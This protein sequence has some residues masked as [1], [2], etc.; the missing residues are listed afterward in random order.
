MVGPGTPLLALLRCIP[1]GIR[2]YCGSARVPPGQVLVV[3]LGIALG[4]A[5]V[6]EGV[7][8]PVDSAAVGVER[9]E[10]CGTGGRVVKV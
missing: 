1:L 9:A 5:A 2:L 7:V 10:S 4:F 6:A 3:A 8:A